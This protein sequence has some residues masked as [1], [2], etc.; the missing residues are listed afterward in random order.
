LYL[1]NITAFLEDYVV[2]ISGKDIEKDGGVIRLTGCGLQVFEKK[3]KPAKENQE[4][5]PQPVKEARP[6]RVYIPSE[7]LN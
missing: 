1:T 6:K 5:M 4:T 3:P 2:M 7:S